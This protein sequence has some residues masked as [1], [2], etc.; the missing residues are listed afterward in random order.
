[1]GLTS[2]FL[3]LQRLHR[4]HLCQLAVIFDKPHVPVWMALLAPTN[5]QPS[6]FKTLHHQLFQPLVKNPV[7]WAMKL[8]ST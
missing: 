6:L 4:T 5:S 1:M 3:C 2:L 7:L 8:G